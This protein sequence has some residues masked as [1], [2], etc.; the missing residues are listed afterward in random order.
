MKK[1]L[2]KLYKTVRSHDKK[3]VDR[4]VIRFSPATKAKGHVLIS[5]IIESFIID[6][7][8]PVYRSHTHY[9]ETRQ[10]VN[11]FVELGYAVD[12]ISY[13]NK[14]FR[15]ERKY[16]I[17]I[18]A[19][20]NFDNIS[21]QLND[22]CKQV[23]HLDTAHWLTNN[24]NA[25]GR[26]YDL[27]QRRKVALNSGIR[28]IERNRAI[29]NADLA[30]VLGNRFTINSYAYAG[31]A[32]HRIPISSPISFEWT[33]RNVNEIRNNYIWFG[34][35]GFVHKGLDLVLEAFA[36]LPD[37]HLFVCGPLEMDKAF[38]QEFHR[39]LYETKNI[40]TVGWVDIHDAKFKDIMDNCL[41]I[42]YP[43]C[44]EG[45]GGSVIDCMRGGVI[46]LV[47]YES[48]VDVGENGIVLKKSSLAEVR[49]EVIRLSNMAAE[50]LREMS[51]ETWKFASSMH[52]Q[53]VFAQKYREFVLDVL[54]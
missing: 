31:K 16:S 1:L 5:Y 18:G 30:T 28:L 48:S 9:W 40:H 3:H 46:P 22:A 11:T 13:R 34:S 25:Y 26:L 41:G 19:R 43:S 37:Y 44:A 8:D 38:L 33:G 42:V 29:E 27:C 14:S 12:L 20:T 35:S 23:A 10:M 39:E 49:E 52:T 4:Q 24:F 17:F 47:S 6:S 32:I 36:G 53:K 7:D 21:A 15:P 45:G 51:H 54:L 50:E 2:R